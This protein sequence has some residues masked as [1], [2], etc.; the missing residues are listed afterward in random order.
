M[1]PCVFIVKTIVNKNVFCIALISYLHCLHH[2]HV[3]FSQCK[4]GQPTFT[5][6]STEDLTMPGSIRIKS[7]K[8]MQGLV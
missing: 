3:L 8:T 7:P 6:W 4:E 1:L 2:M 5:T